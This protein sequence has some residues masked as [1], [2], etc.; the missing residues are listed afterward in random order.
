MPKSRSAYREFPNVSKYLSEK[1]FR[2]RKEMKLSQ[3]ALAERT[4]LTRNCIQ[5]ME[6]HEHLPLP[7]TMFKLTKALEFSEEE[8]ARFWEELEDAYQQDRM[9]QEAKS[10]T[11]EK[12]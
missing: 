1:I 5:Q 4:G 10:G 7:S 11:L 3:S 9:L 6:C 12:V 2:R 8:T